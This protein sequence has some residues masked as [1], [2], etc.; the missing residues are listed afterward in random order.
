[1]RGF[2]REFGLFLKE[3]IL[4]YFRL[5]IK[6]L[7][8]MAKWIKP[9]VMIIRHWLEHDAIES[10]RFRQKYGDSLGQFTNVI[11]PKE[12]KIPKVTY[13]LDQLKKMDPFEFERF[14][15]KQFEKRGYLVKVT[16]ATGDQGIDLDCYKNG[17]RIIV[18]CKRYQKQVPSGEV[19]KFVGVKHFH[20]ADEAYFI[21]TGYFTSA[22]IKYAKKEQIR[23]IDGSE[24]MRWLI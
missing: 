17:K 8:F 18:Q 23:L 21:T 2:L 3:F 10:H 16:K 19:M 5:S 22:G 12:Q 15:G 9:I 13:T 11:A 1:M 24:L 6:A 4:F 7:H 14:I 20:N